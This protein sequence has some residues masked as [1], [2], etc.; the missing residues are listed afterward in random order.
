[1]GDAPASSSAAVGYANA[2][3]EV[4]PQPLSMIVNIPARALAVTKGVQV[5][6]KSARL[7]SSQCSVMDGNEVVS[8]TAYVAFHVSY[9]IAAGRKPIANL[10]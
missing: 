4:Q 6:T 2:R 1:M 8:Y 7:R 5:V 9:Y 3:H 10:G